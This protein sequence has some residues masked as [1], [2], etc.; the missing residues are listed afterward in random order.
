MADAAPT[1]RP[2]PRTES[3]RRLVH[4]NDELRQVVAVLKQRVRALD[5]TS[6]ESRAQEKIQSLGRDVKRLYR[7]TQRQHEQLLQRSAR[8]RQLHDDNT[9][10]QT[11]LTALRDVTWLRAQLTTLQ[12]RLSAPPRATLPP[13]PPPPQPVAHVTHLGLLAILLAQLAILLTL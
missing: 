4:D 3:H 9:R 5:A 6:S 13:P 8:L 1:S 2:A 7:Q 10:L 12:R 11:E